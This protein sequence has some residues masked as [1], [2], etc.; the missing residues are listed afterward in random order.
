[1]I[2]ANGGSV[3]WTQNRASDNYNETLASGKITVYSGGEFYTDQY[4]LENDA[5]TVADY[6]NADPLYA[7]SDASTNADLE[8]GLFTPDSTGSKEVVAI[9]LSGPSP[10]A[11]GVPGVDLQGAM[12]FGNYLHFVMRV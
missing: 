6:T 3:A 4:A 1:V 8:S 7:T 11:S 5:G 12:S 2:G 9:V 10:L